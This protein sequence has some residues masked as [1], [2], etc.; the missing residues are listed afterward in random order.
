MS[1]S[2]AFFSLMVMTIFSRSSG[3]MCLSRPRLCVLVLL[4]ESCRCNCGRE[5]FT[6]AEVEFASSV[7][8]SIASSSANESTLPDRSGISAVYRPSEFREAIEMAGVVDLA[9]SLSQQNV[10]LFHNRQLRFSNRRPSSS[11]PAHLE[12]TVR[13]LAATRDVRIGTIAAHQ[14]TC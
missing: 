13:G 9:S 7:S 2:S 6:G 4:L 3:V 11:D 10:S 8:N 14:S 1:G 12:K 5:M